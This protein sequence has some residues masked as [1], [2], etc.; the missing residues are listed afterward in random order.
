[1]S[2]TRCMAYLNSNCGSMQVFA[3]IFCKK[4]MVFVDYFQHTK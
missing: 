4:R 3:L 2:Y 1:M